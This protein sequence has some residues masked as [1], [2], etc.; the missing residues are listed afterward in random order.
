MPKRQI[1]YAS[2]K[3]I[4][5]SAPEITGKKANIV[6]KDGQVS[7]ATVLNIS[8]SI[9]TIK[10]MRLAQSDIDLNNIAEII[11]DINA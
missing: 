10:N 6:F 4:I 11:L 3:S 1:R 5:E 8:T 9:L 2:K 7:L